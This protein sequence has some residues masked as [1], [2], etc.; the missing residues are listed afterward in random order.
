LFSLR[1]H[2]YARTHTHKHTHNLNAL[3]QNL[4]NILYA[5]STFS[6]MLANLNLLKIS[7]QNVVK[8]IYRL[9]LWF[10]HVFTCCF[11][12]LLQLSLRTANR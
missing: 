3:N 9:F 6:T 7:T 11:C 2:F 8:S 12:L 4:R 10:L 1:F 5:L